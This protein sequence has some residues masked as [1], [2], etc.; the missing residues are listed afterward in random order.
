MRKETEEE[1][2]PLPVA[3]T[4]AAAV[5]GTPPTSPP[6]TPPP[7]TTT[8]TTR[9]D[10]LRLLPL[11]FVATVVLT[12]GVNQGVGEGLCFFAA[13]YLFTDPIAK[14]GLELDPATYAEVDAFSSVPWQVKALY[15]V[16]SDLFPMC[17]LR[18]SPYMFAAAL[19][20]FVAWI[21]L[22]AW[23]PAAL[24]ATWAGL[25][26]FLGNLS[27]A[28]PD[29]MVDAQV[30]LES[31]RAPK[32]ASDLQALCWISFG[33]FKIASLLV[34]PA[35]YE[36]S[37]VRPLFTLTAFT[38][39]VLLGPGWFNWLGE[40]AF[41]VHPEAAAQSGWRQRLADAMAQ[42][43]SA[44]LIRLAVTL[45]VVSIAMGL[46]AL[47]GENHAAIALMA[48]L[49]V[50]PATCALVWRYLASVSA[51]LAKTAIYVF[52]AGALQPS[53]P[54]LFYWM[55]ADE[56]NC[57]LGLPCFEPD[58]IAKL[59][60]VGYC[61]FVLGTFVY[62]RYLTRWSY[63][64]IYA[65]TQLAMAL[66]NLLD[67]VWVLRLNLR[68]GIPDKAFVL[69]EEVV[70]PMLSRFNIMPLFVL[71]AMLCPDGVEATNFAT[72]MG[73]SNFGSSVGDLVGAGLTNALGVEKHKYD[74]LPA[75]VVVRALTRLVPILL[76]PFLVPRGS[77]SDPEA[78]VGEVASTSNSTSASA[79]A[80]T[81]TTTTTAALGVE[82]V[83]ED[84]P[85][86]PPPRRSGSAPG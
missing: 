15:G 67:L 46:F 22:G 60:I 81:A 54:A 66:F 14:G 51:T 39:L 71:A 19:I 41:V 74:G 27:I 4:A 68:V 23:P 45:T 64:A 2:E 33:V 85:L 84:D 10:S 18:R 35:V 79:S 58:F 6:T 55:R 21:A 70:G 78:L 12:Y 31:K 62:N 50:T 29:V 53:S 65:S 80:T 32:L 63:R 25:L 82:M 37:G 56:E 16:A 69:G 49:V 20:G 1:T 61:F 38:A 8:T 57:R 11:R 75:L 59:S 86:L 7:P 34:A 72:I 52:L 43:A 44:A 83:R 9:L 13:Q 26:L 73:L 48:L 28:A 36:S 77:P 3:M 47:R 24:S 76:V 5:A 42:P 30:A 17:G 40:E